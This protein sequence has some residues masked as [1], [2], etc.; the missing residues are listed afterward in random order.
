MAEW[1]WS[2]VS[3]AGL[4]IPEGVVETNG[5]ALWSFGEKS[6]VHVIPVYLWLVRR[7]GE[8]GEMWLVNDV[9]GG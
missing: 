9:A 4:H 6:R 2:S 3:G 8:A 7:L 5:E 1:A